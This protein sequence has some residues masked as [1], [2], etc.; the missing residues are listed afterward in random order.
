MIYVKVPDADQAA[1][2]VQQLGGQ[3]INGPMDI[4]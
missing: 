1:P 4:P 3:V 2:K